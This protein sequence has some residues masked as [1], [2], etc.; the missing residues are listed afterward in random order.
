MSPNSDAQRVSMDCPEIQAACQALLDD[1]SGPSAALAAHAAACEACRPA[2]EGFLSLARA[3]STTVILPRPSPGFADR[4][5]A[6]HA[7]QRR[8]IPT[9]SR[10]GGLAIAA[11]L[12]G[13]VLWRGAT[14]TPKP[15][16]A[17]RPLS[18]SLAEATSATLDLA[19]SASGTAARVG[20]R[21]WEEAAVVE[22]PRVPAVEG[23]AGA[24]LR[25]VGDRLDGNVRPIG[26]S[27][28]AA[29][30]FLLGPS[31]RDG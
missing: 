20:L 15:V 3:V 18:E 12:L 23:D 14:P 8:Q 11:S 25:A 27:A 22:A 19:R 28:R 10:L 16:P 9:Y 7:S 13:A 24:I 21:V 26:G 30:G 6:A 31:R 4:V 1:P 5:L 2:I 17:A 29:F